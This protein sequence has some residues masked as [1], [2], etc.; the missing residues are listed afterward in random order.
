ME[1]ECANGH[2]WLSNSGEVQQGHWCRV[3][4]YGMKDIEYC[5]GL[6]SDWGGRCLSTEY[7]NSRAPVEWQ[8]SAGHR[9]TANVHDVGNG[10]WCP[11]CAGNVKKTISSCEEMANE[12][13]GKCLSTEYVNNSTKLTWL[14][15]RG[16]VWKAIPNTVQQGS[17]CPICAKM[18]SN[19]ELFLFET[20]KGL[21]PDAQSGVRKLLRSKRFELDIYVPS[22][23][24]AIEFDGL[25]WH[26]SKWAEER[27]ALARDT[28]KNEQCNE[29]G[30]ELL[31]IDET[32]FDNDINGVVAAITAFLAKERVW[33]SQ[34]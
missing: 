33:N 20:V 25:F 9:W 29:A 4:S 15:Q 26:K 21:Y 30:I 14:C 23:R 16:H 7:I 13:N 12:F 27:G 1:W 8:C 10:H 18:H 17:W 3:C 34:S 22:L 5:N 32:D 2:R 24:R 6:A 11:E 19:K 31:R 28:R